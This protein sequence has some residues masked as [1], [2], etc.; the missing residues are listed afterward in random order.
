M[1]YGVD[2]YLTI[3][4][5]SGRHGKERKKERERILLTLRQVQE[6]RH[7]AAPRANLAEREFERQHACR[8]LMKFQRSAALATPIAPASTDT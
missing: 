8:V 1:N 2:E 4:F 3:N 5:Y 6:M 7:L